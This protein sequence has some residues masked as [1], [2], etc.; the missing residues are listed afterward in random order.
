[1][2][3]EKPFTGRVRYKNKSYEDEY[4]LARESLV[5]SNL[6]VIAQNE[7]IQAQE[8]IIAELRET[9]RE[10]LETMKVKR[11]YLISKRNPS[12]N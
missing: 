12:E 8:R 6:T 9:I 7:T 5:K 1:M 3:K 4:I 2:K 10:Q 11:T